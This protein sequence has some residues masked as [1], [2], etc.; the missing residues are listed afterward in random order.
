MHGTLARRRFTQSHLRHLRCVCV[1]VSVCVC[2]CLCVCLSLCLCLNCF[3]F[4]TLSHPFLLF[5]LL[6]LPPPHSRS[7]S[8]PPA[9]P[10][11]S[12]G[13]ASCRV[14]PVACHVL[15]SQRIC[16]GLAAAGMWW[17]CALRC[18]CSRQPTC[19]TTGGCL[20][21]SVTAA[22]ATAVMMMMMMQLGRAC[23]ML[24]CTLGSAAQ[25]RW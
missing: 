21:G 6:R 20:C 7:L 19:S 18:C 14:A 13:R 15:P 8:T 4:L 3:Y 16:A 17:A 11:M 12:Q 25:Q 5:F 24:R 2:V 23:S 1:C 10:T 9:P 22:T